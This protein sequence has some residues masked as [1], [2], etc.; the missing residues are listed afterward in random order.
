MNLITNKSFERYI[1]E[2]I[3]QFTY[4]DFAPRLTITALLQNLPKYF[5]KKMLIGKNTN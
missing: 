5:T 4:S 1:E 2:C 3:S